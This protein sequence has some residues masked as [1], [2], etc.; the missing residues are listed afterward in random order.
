MTRERIV[1]ALFVAGGCLIGAALA[2]GLA[3]FVTFG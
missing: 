2:W 1:E 3:W